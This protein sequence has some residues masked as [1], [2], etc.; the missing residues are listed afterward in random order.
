MRWKDYGIGTLHSNW[1]MS[2]HAS[3]TFSTYTSAHDFTDF[4]HLPTR[5]SGQ[6]PKDCSVKVEADAG[7]GFLASGQ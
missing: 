4:E 6:C 7:V 3:Q 1:L 2:A 5:R